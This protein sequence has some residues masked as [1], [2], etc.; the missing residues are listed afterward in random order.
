LMEVVSRSPNPKVFL[1]KQDPP[2]KGAQH[3]MPA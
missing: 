3:V 2:R 1:K